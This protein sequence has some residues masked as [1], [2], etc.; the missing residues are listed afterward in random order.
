MQKYFITAINTDSG[1]TIVSAILTETLKADYFKP[2]QA[3]DL[4]N[5]DSIKVQNLISNQETII[6]DETYRLSLPMSPH[7]AAK[8]DNV[9]IDIDKILIP[10]KYTST[11]P[12]IIEG[13]GG[14][15]VPLNDKFFMID[16]MKKM[17]HQT[18]IEIILVVNFYLGSINHTLLSLKELHSQN[19]NV[20]GL[21]FN[22]NINQDSKQIILKHSPYKELFTIRHLE[23]IDKNIIKEESTK[24]A[25]LKVL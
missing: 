16:L 6:H 11:R 2:I 22:G 19:I 24:I 13:A 5:S 25:E 15:M 8:N 17:N 1:K 3:G 14:L 20:K 10:K 12:L 23:Q 4:N 7:A 9:L 18:D 21:I